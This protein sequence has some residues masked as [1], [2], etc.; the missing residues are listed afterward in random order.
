MKQLKAQFL[1][2]LILI[3]GTLFLYG[4]V[5]N[6]EFS[7]LDD[8]L[9]IEENW[10]HLTDFNHVITAFNEDVFNGAE[11]TYYRPIQVLSHMP[12]A[13]IAQS[14]TPTPKIFFQ[15]NLFFFITAFVLLYFFL[16]E[17]GFS[18][19]YRFLFSSFLAIHPT[20]TPAVAWIPGRVDI[21]LF[22]FVIISIWSFIK[23]FKSNNT[24]WLVIHFMFFAIGIFTKETTIAVPFVSILFIQYLAL[25]PNGLHQGNGWASIFSLKFWVGTL[26]YS[27]KWLKKHYYLI[28]VYTL[29]LIIWAILRKNALPDNPFG[30]KGFVFHIMYCWKELVVLCGSIFLPFNLQVFLEFSWPFFAFGAIGTL[31][32]F[33][34]PKLIHTSFKEL[35]IAVSWMFLFIFPTVLSDFIN[36]HR[37]FVPLVGMAFILKPLDT[38]LSLK[39]KTTG[40]LALLFGL[41]LWQSMTFKKAFNTRISFW[42][43]AIE[44]SPNSAFANNGLA[45]SFHLDNELDSALKYYQRVI[46]IRPDRENVRIGMALIHEGRDE[47]F[48]ADSLLQ[49]EF[50]ATKDSSQVYFYMG[51]VQLERGDT[52]QAIKNLELGL[53]AQKSSR[54]ARIYY[55][56]LGISVKERSRQLMDFNKN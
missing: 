45:W 49:S 28:L 43:N 44:Y 7:G 48:I 9:M 47:T 55:D 20:L 14:E 40:I 32:F 33:L 11:G 42:N 41:F 31:L 29:I 54:I 51:Q 6:N 1:Y 2:P 37:M 18:P 16:S 12:D 30:F 4:N 50:L 24:F 10:D 38:P 36:Y 17:F 23:Y 8:L 34:V 22:L 15:L 39:S 25:S 21:I 13:L 53:P 5:V 26:N 56:T 52:N 27:L 35:F 19:G 3:I 46:E